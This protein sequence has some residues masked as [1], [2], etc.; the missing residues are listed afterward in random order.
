MSGF[1]LTGVLMG[2]LGSLVVA[3]RYQFDTDPRIVGL[4][5]LTF[6]AAV[7]AAGYVTQK[8][9][10][11]VPLHPYFPLGMSARI[12]RLSGA[13]VRSTSTVDLVANHWSGALGLASGRT[14]DHLVARSAPIF[15]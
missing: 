2:M 15:S 4:H 1:L 9:L 7:L 12:Y 8:R 3:W 5:S 11:D 14:D 10:R 13:G 6:N